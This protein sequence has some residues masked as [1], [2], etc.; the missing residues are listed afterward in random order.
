MELDDYL[1]SKTRFHLGFNAG[2]Q[3]PAGDRSRL[4][5]A[6]ALIPDNYWYEQIV[7]HIK[8]LILHGEQV[9]RFLMITSMQMEAGS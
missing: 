4:E 6:M 9:L 7:H 8:R 5:E 3:I 1:K 2:A